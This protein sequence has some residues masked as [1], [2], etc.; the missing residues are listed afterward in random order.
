MSIEYLW[1]KTCGQITVM[2]CHNRSAEQRLVKEAWCY[3]GLY[4]KTIISFISGLCCSVGN[5]N[6]ALI[7]SSELVYL[8]LR[9]TQRVP[10]GKQTGFTTD[11]ISATWYDTKKNEIIRIVADPNDGS[12]FTSPKYEGRASFTKGFDLTLRGVNDGDTG[13]YKCEIIT[14]TDQVNYKVEV[15]VI[16]KFE[17][18]VR[19]HCQLANGHF[20]IY[21]F[22]YSRNIIYS[23]SGQ[24]VVHPQDVCTP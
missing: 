21:F 7:V 12:N 22:S 17:P 13:S 4:R 6:D 19:L 15:T 8:Q 24:K 14:A 20:S 18:L 11:V 5:A 2:V 23:L 1:T 3:K 16:G 9:Q 10:C